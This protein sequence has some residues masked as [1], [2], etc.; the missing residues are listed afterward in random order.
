M[1]PRQFRM[2]QNYYSRPYLAESSDYFPLP[3]FRRKLLDSLIA[4]RGEN[5][6]QWW[7]I[8]S[9]PFEEKEKSRKLVRNRT[10][11]E[12][13]FRPR[14]RV[15]NFKDTNCQRPPC[16]CI[17]SYFFSPARY[18]VTYRH[19]TPTILT[20]KLLVHVPPVKCAFFTDRV[21]PS[22]I[23]QGEIKIDLSRWKSTYM[24]TLSFLRD[25]NWNSLG[26]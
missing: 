18:V 11:N 5:W 21:K 26:K 15:E 10:G 16:K 12:R 6:A 24:A 13:L 2:P 9:S 14:F 7:Y 8:T 23:Y 19:C 4:K 22:R 1:I 20:T 3:R 17:Y 25:V